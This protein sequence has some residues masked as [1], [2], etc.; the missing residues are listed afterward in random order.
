KAKQQI[1]GQLAMSEENKNAY[2]LMMA[3]SLLDLNKLP[4][5]NDIFKR[6]DAITSSQLQDLA[7]ETLDVS[8]MSSLT[9]LPE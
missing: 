3:K 4:N 2:M 8:Q 1:K 5:L 9:Y 6:I 7:I